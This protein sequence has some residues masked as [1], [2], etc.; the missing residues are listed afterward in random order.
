MPSFVFRVLTARGERGCY[1]GHIDLSNVDHVD[2]TDNPEFKE[3]GATVDH[4][5]MSAREVS[6]LI[7]L[8]TS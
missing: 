4:E 5:L 7:H 6:A 8:L 1:S 2:S 3:E